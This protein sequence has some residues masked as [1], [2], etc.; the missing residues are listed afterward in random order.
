[1]PLFTV[2]IGYT[3]GTFRGHPV[4]LLADLAQQHHPK[5]ADEEETNPWKTRAAEI[6]RWILCTTPEADQ[7]V[8]ETVSAYLMFPQHLWPENESAGF[9]A[10]EFAHEALSELQTI[11]DIVAL[12]NLSIL[13]G[14]AIVQDV[15][16]QLGGHLTSIYT[17]YNLRA[18][19]PHSRCWQ[20]IADDHGVSPDDIVHIGDLIV[21]DIY[22]AL[23]AGCGRAILVNTGGHVVPRTLSEDSRVTVVHDLREA[24]TAID[25]W[26]LASTRGAAEVAADQS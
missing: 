8:I 6:N 11:G 16:A 26:G 15:E 10:Y 18:C 19:K 22:G 9:R 21:E 7:H 5:T 23:N 2:D 4:E 13:G 1:M 24:V 25:S 20:T 14:S 3:M 17:S 12:S